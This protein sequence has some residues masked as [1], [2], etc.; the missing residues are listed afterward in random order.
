MT[1]HVGLLLGG[2]LC[3]M[4]LLLP[5]VHASAASAQTVWIQ[6][7]DSCRHATPGARQTLDG[8]S[9]IGP[10]GGTG[11]ANVGSGPCPLP[12]GSCT[13]TTVGCASFTVPIPTGA[14][15]THTITQTAAQAAPNS[16]PCTGGSACRSEQASFTISSTGVVQAR[17]TNVYPD[18]FQAWYPSQTGFFAGTQK[19]PVIFH[20]FVLGTGSCDGDGDADDRLTGTPSVHCDSDGD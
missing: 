17:T 10:G 18:G 1:R 20:D 12:R 2:L 5:G 6:T 13:V 7:L 9:V 19:D 4:T 11:E 16:V 15:V 8:S 3:V 14:P